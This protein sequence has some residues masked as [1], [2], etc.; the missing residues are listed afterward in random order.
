MKVVEVLENGYTVLEDGRVLSPKNELLTA[1]EFAELQ[2]RRESNRLTWVDLPEQ[3]AVDLLEFP[4]NYAFKLNEKKSEVTGE[5]EV[6]TFGLAD[7][8]GNFYLV[9][10]GYPF[11]GAATA[12]FAEVPLRQLAYYLNRD[13]EDLAEEFTQFVEEVF[14]TAEQVGSEFE[15]D[16]E[17]T[18]KVKKFIRGGKVY[19]L[20]FRNGVVSNLKELGEVHES[21][22][23]GKARVPKSHTLRN[24]R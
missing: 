12:R 17:T 9:Q 4:E 8:E 5:V 10:F 22:R 14:G 13:R 3:E 2:R 18:Y 15:A 21:A 20:V 16:E 19:S 23:V 6:E 7:N 24:V 11:G 1:E